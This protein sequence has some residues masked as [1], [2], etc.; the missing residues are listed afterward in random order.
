MFD[1]NSFS[2]SELYFTILQLLR[3]SS[4]WIRGGMEDLESLVEASLWYY[5]LPYV[6]N[7]AKRSPDDPTTSNVSRVLQQNWKNVI[8]HQ[9]NLCKPLLDRIEKKTEEVKSLRDGVSSNCQAL[10][11]I[12]HANNGCSFSMQRQCVKPQGAQHSTTIS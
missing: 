8:S 3:I 2:R 7:R 6:G 12:I 4:E 1:N 9:K 10:Q 11:P 5:E